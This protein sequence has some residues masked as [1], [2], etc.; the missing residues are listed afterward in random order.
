MSD[1]WYSNIY[2]GFF[3]TSAIAFIIGFFSS[4]YICLNAYIAG[5]SILILAV[6]M[7]LVVL[8]NKVL[9]TAKDNSQTSF[10]VITN[11]LLITGPFLLMLFV[12][13][14]LL[15]LMIMNNGKIIRGEVSDS[16]YSFSNI[17]VFLMLVQL[18]IV[19]SSFSGEDFAKKTNFSKVTSLIIFLIGILSAINTVN[20][21][22]ILTYFVT[23]GFNVIQ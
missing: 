6:M 3:L 5:Y 12:I 15:R 20:I 1:K 14:V 11:I 19:Y 22:M 13:A 17:S 23:D 9:K 4:R 10:T 8:F 18:Y 21:Y 7:L 16:Y 2:K